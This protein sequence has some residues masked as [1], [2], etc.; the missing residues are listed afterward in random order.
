MIA[1]RKDKRGLHDLMA[2][3]VVVQKG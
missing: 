1:F 3:T 2:G